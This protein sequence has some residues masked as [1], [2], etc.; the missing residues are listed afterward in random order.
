M[1]DKKPEPKLVEVTLAKRHTHA[2][3]VYDVGKKIKVTELERAWLIAEK[4]IN[5]APAREEGAK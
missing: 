4:I 3:V 5:E 2:G 1:N